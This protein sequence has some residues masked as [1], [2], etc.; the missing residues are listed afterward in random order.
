MAIPSSSSHSAA[1]FW[2]CTAGCQQGVTSS[3][4]CSLHPG[5][6]LP[7]PVNHLQPRCSPLLSSPNFASQALSSCLEDLSFLSRVIVIQSPMPLLAFYLLSLTALLDF[8]KVN[9][10][11]TLVTKMLPNWS[12]PHRQFIFWSLNLWAFLTL[13]FLPVPLGQFAS[14]QLN[15]TRNFVPNIPVLMWSDSVTLFSLTLFHFLMHYNTLSRWTPFLQLLSS[16]PSSILNA[17]CIPDAQL[18]S[19]LPINSSFTQGL[20]VLLVMLF[21]YTII[22]PDSQ[23]LLQSH[24]LHILY[25]LLPLS[26][27]TL[28]FSLLTSIT[29]SHQLSLQSNLFYSSSWVAPS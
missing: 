19:T 2:P 5:T 28:I 4:P 24:H 26:N 18:E 22:L 7:P 13:V 1:H 11:F 14:F 17:S 27:S 15:H 3:S 10:D 23:E 20:D 25:L 21:Q 12:D 9:Q 8:M 6:L 16:V 29:M